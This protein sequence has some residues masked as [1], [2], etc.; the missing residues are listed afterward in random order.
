MPR[1]FWPLG[2]IVLGFAAFLYMNPAEPNLGEIDGPEPSYQF[3]SVS[4]GSWKGMSLSAFAKQAETKIGL[5]YEWG[6]GTNATDAGRDCSG[7][8]YDTARDLG[9]QIPRTAT[10]QLAAS[11]QIGEDEARSTPGAFVWLRRQSDDP[12]GRWK[13]GDIVHVGISTGD[14]HTIEAWTS[15]GVIR[16]PWGWW[17]R[18]YAAYPAVFGRLQGAVQ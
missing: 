4:T 17:R 1:W 10:G 12:R 8:G 13:A 14:G 5:P 2:F 7:L 9:Y 3:A 18:S 6:G 15:R 16:A 11:E